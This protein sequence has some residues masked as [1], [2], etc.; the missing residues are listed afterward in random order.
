[1]AASRYF[2]SFVASCSA[3]TPGKNVARIQS[4]SVS[5]YAAAAAGR[6]TGLRVRRVVGLVVGFGSNFLN[7]ISAEGRL[8]L[9][10][11]N[12]RAHTL[13]EL[14]IT[15]APCV[16]QEVTRRDELKVIG[17]GRL[18]RDPDK[19]LKSPRPPLLKDFT[20][21]GLSRKVRLVKKTRQVRLRFEVE[22]ES[23]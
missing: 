14:G 12:H 20:D 5:W 6:E 9:N 8:V 1:M 17:G 15:H 7:V 21:P 22:E 18:R 3:I 10:N 23:V 4:L 13:R 11:G 2:E 16:V 19:F